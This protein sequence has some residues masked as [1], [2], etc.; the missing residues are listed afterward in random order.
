MPLPAYFLWKNDMTETIYTSR[1]RERAFTGRSSR[2]AARQ[3]DSESVEQARLR[4]DALARMLDSAF[5]IPGTTVRVGADAALNLIPGLG[6]LAA[7][8]VASYII[9]E[10]RRLGVP[11]S[12]LLRMMGNV[13]VDFVISAV[14]VIGWF[15]DIFFRANSRNIALIRRHL[16]RRM[17]R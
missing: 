16:D 17:V 9:Y 14:P 7:K 15:G 12:T 10:A 4:L 5:T 11:T 1:A 8:G 6:T 2:Q 3:L 13:G